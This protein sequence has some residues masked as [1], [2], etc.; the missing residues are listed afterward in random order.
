MI[1]QKIR[2][3]TSN[4]GHMAFVTAQHSFN[5]DHYDAQIIGIASN[6]GMHDSGPHS[7]QK[8]QLLFAQAGCMSI[9]LADRVC[10][11][12][13]TRAAWIPAGMEHRV[14]MTSVVAYRSLY[15]DTNI[16]L[17]DNVCVIEVNPLLRELIER[18]AYWE[19]DKP[20]E[21]QMATQTLFIE[22]LLSAP[23]EHWQLRMPQNKRL[24]EWLSAIKF[25][26]ENPPQLQRLA[27]KVGMSTK[28]IGRIFT[29]ETG[30]S[31]QAWRQQWR[32]LHAL[33]L[34]AEK[35]SISDIASKLEF[36]SDSAFIS[37]FKQQT[38]QT[39]LKYIR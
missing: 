20:I 32:L 37:F 31:Y 22:E 36:S 19:W 35:N 18:I 23:E 9:E 10:F 13:P 14:L 39:P 5:P 38:G 4:V 28:T 27:E 3:N 1:L 7:H 24:Y 12:P 33:E 17:I 16:Q 11:L 30:M 6:F 15:L 29:A 26:K 8:H 21:E 25:K 2:P 34:L